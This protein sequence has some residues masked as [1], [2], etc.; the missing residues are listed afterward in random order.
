MEHLFAVWPE[1]AERLRSAGHVLLLADYDG[2]L[3]PIVERPELARLDEG[4]R[5]LLETLV[6]QRRITVGIISGRALSDLVAKVRVEGVV[7][8]GNHGLEIQGPGLSFT[9]P[10]AGEVRSVLEQISQSLARALVA[11]PGA[12]VEDKGLS[13]SVHYRMVPPGHTAELRAAVEQAVAG[14]AAAGKVRLTR[15]K[16][17]YEVRPAVE[18]DKGKAIE[19]L[20]E[21]CGGVGRGLLLIYVGD[22][23]TD[24]DAFR[25]IQRYGEGL[26]VFVGDG[27]RRTSA[28]YYLESSAEVV[29]FLSKLAEE[30]RQRP[31]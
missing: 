7:Y 6:S 16:K 11:T 5:R 18:W 30:I 27:K 20:I 29:Q 1:V 8:A 26:S 2:T 15:G 24:E 12:L 21:R 10:V 3:T 17:V 14:P 19:L 31:R 23:V 25:Y 4:T 9:I 13:I 22:D 28:R